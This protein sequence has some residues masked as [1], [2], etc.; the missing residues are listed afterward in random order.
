MNR[1]ELRIRLVRIDKEREM[2][3]NYLKHTQNHFAKTI[4][5]NT[6]EYLNH[7][8]DLI[9]EQLENFQE[10]TYEH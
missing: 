3:L 6:L 7:Q 5:E 10:K 1:Q 8:T 4:Y 2:V 9:L